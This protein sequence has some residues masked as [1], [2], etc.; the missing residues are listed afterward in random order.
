MKSISNVAAVIPAA[1]LG[2][3]MG[4]GRNKVWLS[5]NGEPVIGHTLRAFMAVPAVARIVLVVHADEEEIFR[6]YLENAWPD[7]AGTRIV[8]TTGGKE[9][10]DSVY[11]GLQSLEEWPEWS[12]AGRRLVAIHDA[13]RALLTPQLLEASL[14]AGWE[15][16]A[17]GVAVPVKDTIKQVDAAGYVSATPE[18]AALRAIQTPQVF[19]FETI[20]ACYKRLSASGR[21][22]SDDCGVAEACGERVKLIEGSYENL[23]ITTPEDL[24]LAEAILRRR[25]DADRSGI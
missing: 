2:R 25:A 1:G 4:S 10:Q 15:Y 13:A 9:R 6:T 19:D 21:Y 7:Q 12:R 14:A 20:L 8:L 24:W 17:V 23:K 18:R 22:F 5:L 3:R 11:R 16:G